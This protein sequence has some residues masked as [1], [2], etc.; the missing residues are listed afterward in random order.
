MW[1]G[2]VDQRCWCRRGCLVVAVLRP[3][4]LHQPR[5]RLIP[6]LALVAGRAFSEA[7]FG[8]WSPVIG[9]LCWP[10][11]CLMLLRQYRRLWVLDEYGLVQI[12]PPGERARTYDGL[13]AVIGVCVIVALAGVV[14]SIIGL[15]WILAAVLGWFVAGIG[16]TWWTTEHHFPGHLRRLPPGLSSQSRR[17]IRD[18]TKAASEVEMLAADSGH[19]VPLMLATRAHLN[20]RY[21]GQ[22]VL[23]YARTA[24]H[25]RAYRAL[26]KLDQPYAGFGL[27]IRLEG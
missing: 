9:W 20:S 17:R 13:L 2:E 3:A 6:Q 11:Y 23:A 19:G 12:T 14:L 18:L 27:L 22:T 1:A 24:K 25:A 4:G 7:Q 16:L 21:P 10:V 8:R 26:L 5:R 15:D